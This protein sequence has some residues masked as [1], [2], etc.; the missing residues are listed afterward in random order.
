M[1]TILCL[2]AMM[3]C[4]AR[5]D[6]SV[7]RLDGDLTW[8]VTVPQCQFRLKGGLQ[9]LSSTSTGTIKLALW[10]TKTPYPSAG[11]NV[12]EYTFGQIPPSSQLGDFTVK[13][14]STLPAANGIYYFTITVLE[15]TLAGWRN[16]LLVPAGTRAVFNGNFDGQPKWVFP[17][18]PV[19]APPPSIVTGDVI[20]LIERAT[21]EFNKFPLVWQE[22][23][24]LTANSSSKMKYATRYRDATARYD[25]SVQKVN[26]KG[27]K[28][29]YGKLVLTNGERDNSTFKN[30]VS[31]FFL[32]ANYGTYKSI[33]TGNLLGGTTFNS[34]TTWGSFKLQ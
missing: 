5:V 29:S 4:L 1:K 2:V 3:F 21:G 6:A 28:V 11:Y 32:G 10:A 34:A 18:A 23:I 19:V 7:L 25:Y 8:N 16:V 13:T 22:K 26:L 20:K 33:V 14:K 17:I 24:T 15:Y 27:R 9:N 30:T 12:G 31:L